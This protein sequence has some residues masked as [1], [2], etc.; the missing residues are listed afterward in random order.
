MKIQN[1]LPRTVAPVNRR[2][3]AFTAKEDAFSPISP[4]IDDKCTFKYTHKFPD[5]FSGL[6]TVEK[7]V[8]PRCVVFAGDGAQ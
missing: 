8:Q 4:S 1:L 3:V 7:Y 2:D 6:G 5:T